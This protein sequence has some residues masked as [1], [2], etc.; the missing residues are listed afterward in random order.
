[1]EGKE[2]KSGNQSLLV[3]LGP[4][5]TKSGPSSMDDP[6]VPTILNRSQYVSIL[7]IRSQV[8]PDSP[9]LVLLFIETCHVVC[10]QTDSL[11]WKLYCLQHGIQPD[12]RTSNDGVGHADDNPFTEFFNDTGSSRYVSRAVFVDLEPMAVGEQGPPRA[13]RHR[14]QLCSRA[15]HC[16]KGSDQVVGRVRKLSDQ[17]E[18]LQ[19][20][21]VFHSFGGE[22]GLGS[23]SLLM[24]FQGVRNVKLTEFQT[25]LIPHQHINSPLSSYAPIVFAD[26]AFHEELSVNGITKFHG[27]N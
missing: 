13:G 8:V 21:L 27:S 14:K 9:P 26:W 15:L 7:L 6:S 22:T 2:D 18:G 24:D 11:C 5:S 20:F 17:R 10:T 3:D 19:G 12:G 16:W 23:T 4:K 25:N 1:M